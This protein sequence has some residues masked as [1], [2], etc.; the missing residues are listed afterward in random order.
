MKKLLSSI[1]LLL[2]PLISMVGQAR[3]DNTNK[4]LPG[5]MDKCDPY[6]KAQGGYGYLIKNTPKADVW[7]SE[8]IYKVMKDTPVASRKGGTVK[9]S[10]ARNEYESFIVVIN[11]KETLKRVSVRVDGFEDGTAARSDGCS[12]FDASAGVCATVRK[13]EYVTTYYTND[14]YGWPGEW[15]DPLPLYGQPQDAPTGENTSFWITLYTP[16]G[17]P[18]GTIKGKVTLSDASGWNVTIPVS[19]KVRDITLPATPTLHSGFGLRFDHVIAYENLKTQEQQ[20]ESFRNYMETYRDYRIS[21]SYAPFYLT[22]AIFSYSG[23]DWKG[24]SFDP[25]IKAAGKYS[26]VV[27]D[28]SY[29]KNIAARASDGFIPICPGN[30][31]QIVFDNRSESPAN[32]TVRIDCYDSDLNKLPYRS[33]FLHFA[34]G[35]EWKSDTLTIERLPKEA[36]YA[37]I[38]LYGTTAVIGGETTGRTWYDNIRFTDLS[39]G[40]N[41]LPQGDFEPDA[42]RFRVNIDWSGFEKTA[43]RYYGETPWFTGFTFDI[44]VL[45]NA[46]GF[47]FGTEE[48]EMLF[49]DCVQQIEAEFEKLNLLDKAYIYWVDEPFPD[50]YPGIRAT[51]ALIKKHAPRLRPFIAEQFPWLAGNE[52][53]PRLDI[54][55]VTDIFCVSWNCLD[56]HE[57]VERVH[58]MPGKE[59][60]TYLCTATRAPFFTNF[61]D[62]DGIDMRMWIW[63][64]RTL[65]LKGILIWRNNYW[66][67]FS[68]TETG[69]FK[70]AWEE[71]ASFISGDVGARNYEMN[72]K[73]WGNGDG[74]MFYHNNRAPGIDLDTPYTGR[75]IPCVRLEIL[76]DGIEDYEY[77]HLLEEKIPGMTPSDARKARSLLTLPRTVFQDDDATHGEKYYIKDPQY[78]LQRR[79]QIATLLVKYR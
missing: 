46:C 41:L 5:E 73:I 58:K 45:H 12:G 28:G 31:Y 56:D 33:H 72:Q 1:L 40:D 63:A 44:P 22:P 37:S 65:D 36:A 35:S 17:T 32:S 6:M 67:A 77:L 75:P 14:D 64:T 74:M 24:G 60:W 47:P 18:P 29:D 19:L 53:A 68:A 79:E 71:P 4:K 38:L 61:I 39:T 43:A 54:V 20:E 15:P 42:S 3:N 2:M 55:D 13:V 57:K 78:L 7:W 66:T 59:V 8:G 11:P 30:K 62:H 34:T 27:T 76:R 26:Y 23:I 52:N 51:N 50:A 16:A 25:N 48:H 49:K 69:A 21:P 10:T 70:S 9:L